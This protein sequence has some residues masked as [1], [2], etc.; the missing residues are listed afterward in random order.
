MSRVDLNF[1]NLS[2]CSQTYQDPIMSRFSTS[3]RLPCFYPFLKSKSPRAFH[4]GHRYIL[5]FSLLIQS[6]RLPRFE[7]C[8]YPT[9][10]DG[11][12]HI[13]STAQFLH[14]GKYSDGHGSMGPC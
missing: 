4:N 1:F 8:Q 10:P 14:Q 9:N 7:T 13:P 5:R 3:T 6:K 2:S 11:G 12:L